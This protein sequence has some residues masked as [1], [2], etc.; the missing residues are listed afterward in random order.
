MENPPQ[1]WA[2]RLQSLML[3]SH[4]CSSRQQTGGPARDLGLLPQGGSCSEGGDSSRHRP[5]KTRLSH[6]TH[7]LRT[8]SKITV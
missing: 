7:T 2:P 4:S 6:V 1:H 8:R 3:S 5:H